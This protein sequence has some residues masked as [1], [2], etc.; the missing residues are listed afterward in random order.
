MP[1]PWYSPL[2]MRHPGSRNDETDRCQFSKSSAQ[3]FVLALTPHSSHRRTS[4]P[5]RGTPYGTRVPKSRVFPLS[6]LGTY[7]AISV[8]P[9]WIGIRAGAYRFV[10]VGSPRQ[11]TLERSPLRWEILGRRVGDGREIL[12]EPRPGS[13]ATN[14]LAIRCTLLPARVASSRERPF[15]ARVSI[16]SPGKK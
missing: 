4:I 2:V 3:M 6:S 13:I 16:S 7:R 8:G 14:S 9:E 10:Q 11:A 1:E 15:V 5:V 12:A